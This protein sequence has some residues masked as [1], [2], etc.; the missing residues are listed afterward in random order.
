MMLNLK[1]I[2][3]TYKTG[4]FFLCQFVVE[5]YHCRNV[6]CEIAGIIENPNNYPG[7]NV[8]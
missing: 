1:G 7:N 8:N 5:W 4:D 6:L 2:T 3:K